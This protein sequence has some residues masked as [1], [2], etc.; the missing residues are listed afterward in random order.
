MK[1][2]G[3]PREGRGAGGRE[4]KDLGNGRRPWVNLDFKGF[5]WYKGYIYKKE[6]GLRGSGGEFHLVE[7]SAPRTNANKLAPLFPNKFSTLKRQSHSARNR[8]PFPFLSV[9]YRPVHVQS[10]T[11]FEVV[12]KYHRTLSSRRWH[13]LDSFRSPYR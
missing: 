3:N 8:G 2:I 5:A 10:G 1:N 4:G 13:R 11:K 6:S 12:L 7:L 9:L